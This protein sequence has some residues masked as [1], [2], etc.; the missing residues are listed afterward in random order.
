MKKVGKS[1]IESVD[2]MRGFAVLWMVLFQTLDF[3]SKDFQMYDHTWYYFLD[4]V[5]WLPI[6]MFVS[7]I[8]VWLMV[9]KRLS[10][11]FSRQKI[12][13]HSLKRYG[14]YIFLSLLL[15]LWCF[16]FQTFLDLNEILVA[17]GVY[18]FVT[19]CLLLVFFG[20]EWTFI[21]LA[22]VVYVLSFWFRDPLGFQFFPFY[23]ML[24]LFFLGA[25]SAKLITR[26][27]LKKSMLFGFLLLVIIA[28]L[29]LLGDDFSYTGKSLG[30]VLFNV[31]LI[32][33]LF[34]VVNS[35]QHVKFL[36]VFSFAGRNALFFYV[37]HYA[38]W[39]K[40]AVSLNIFQ[41]FDWPSSIL[42]TCF[43]VAVIFPFACLKLRL[44]QCFKKIVPRRN[45]S[46]SSSHR[47]VHK[48]KLK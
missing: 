31:F 22:L 47:R 14:S 4:F 25:F 28:I 29:A 36:D 18:A 24:P 3:F 39:F 44:S 32:V 42:L 9:N 26:K 7:G 2:I 13:F 40:L 38:V 11:G 43:G 19:V 48:L 6:F 21:P 34:A 8:S 46:Y 27:R 17:I 20:R 41:T 30:F 15:C 35:F 5:N 16:S 23:W 1:R 45:L 37:F 33:L 10:S 12:L